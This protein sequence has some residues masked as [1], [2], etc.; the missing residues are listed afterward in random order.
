[1]LM[2]HS[3]LNEQQ[4]HW[5]QSF[6]KNSEMFGEQPSLAAL[7]ATEILKARGGKDILELGAGQGRDTLH[8]ARN[9][10]H[11]HVLEYTREGVEHIEKKAEEYGLNDMITVTQ[12]DVRE[13]FPLPEN[14]L[15]GCYSHM[16][17]C[18]A[19]TSEELVKLNHHVH[20]VIRPGAYNLYTVRH[21]GDVHYGKGIHRGEDLYEMGGFIVHFF[22]R[23]KVEN[24]TDGYRLVD[25][26]EFE[27]GG[28]PRRLY[29]VTLEKLA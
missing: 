9:G 29:Q 21:K 22:D 10:V 25:V 2:D 7:R 20:N 24:L 15:D 13:P 6:A 1:M 23:V 28:L 8:F 11:V 12:H 26:H 14:S 27:E 18:M 19:L 5:E 4:T 16:L 17:Y 3:L